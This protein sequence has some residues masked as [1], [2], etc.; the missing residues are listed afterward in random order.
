MQVEVDDE[1]TTAVE[2]VKDF[3]RGHK[4]KIGSINIESHETFKQ[5]FSLGTNWFYSSLPLADIRAVFY[6]IARVF[7]ARIDG[8]EDLLRSDQTVMMTADIW[9]EATAAGTEQT[10]AN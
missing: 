6:S 7:S 9:P 2:E 8:T 1:P 5:A 10:L 4:G 3:M